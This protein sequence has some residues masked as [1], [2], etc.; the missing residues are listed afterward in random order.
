[1]ETIK[2]ATQ[3][4][5]SVIMNCYNSAEFLKEAIDS[6]YRQTISGWEIIFWD[7]ASTDASAGIAK[8]Y[9]SRLRYFHGAINLPLGEAR[10]KAVAEARGEF[11]AFLDCDDI[12][13]PEKLEKQLQIFSTDDNLALVYTNT[14]KFQN[15]YEVVDFREND[16]PPPSGRIFEHLLKKDFITLSSAMC[17]KKHLLSLN[18]IFNPLF[19][20]GEDWELWLRLCYYFSAGYVPEPLTKWRINPNSMTH[21]KFLLYSA[22]TKM[23]I[24]IL[25]NLDSRIGL[26]Y[27]DELRA[28]EDVAIYYQ[29]LGLW[30]EGRGHE[31]R[32]TLRPH[33]K[34]SIK[35]F[36]AY[37]ISFFPQNFINFLEKIYFRFRLNK[38]FTR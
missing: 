26:E 36:L 13:L 7:N 15:N 5:V 30:F 28:L 8:N 24:D 12:W 38:L 35:F 37:V 23:I 17:R 32:R 27:S 9:D 6:V 33:V 22:E 14:V 11:I 19:H 2:Q 3:P 25:K 10:N 34:K 29:G 21:K 20:V 16:E 18:S 31:A 1:M 4:R